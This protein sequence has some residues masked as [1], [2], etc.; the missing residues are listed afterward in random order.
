MRLSIAILLCGALSGAVGPA[1]FSN[2][3]LTPQKLTPQG[4]AV[5]VTVQ[6][7]APAGIQAATAQVRF[8]SGDETD[9]ALQQDASGAWTAAL[10]IGPN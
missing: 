9:T 8:P 7:T 5:T 3:S 4:G 10:P 1:S 6:I 2:L